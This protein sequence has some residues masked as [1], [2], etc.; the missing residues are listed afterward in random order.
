MYLK[1]WLTQG[2]FSFYK[3]NPEDALVTGIL[4]IFFYIWTF[5]F[6]FTSLQVLIP[7][8]SN[9]THYILLCVTQLVVQ[10]ACEVT[11]C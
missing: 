4:Y 8:P 2:L 5:Y 9:F 3:M 11:T 1:Q 7:L 6:T 10:K